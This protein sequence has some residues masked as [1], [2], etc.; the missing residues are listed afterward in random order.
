ML[1]YQEH[2]GTV[3]SWLEGLGGSVGLGA[4]I[5]AKVVRECDIQERE[6]ERERERES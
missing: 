3:L 4:I 1:V 6:R 5:Y 2:S